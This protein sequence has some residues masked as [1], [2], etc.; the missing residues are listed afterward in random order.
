MLI[1]GVGVRLFL[2]GLSAHGRAGFAALAHALVHADG[3]LSD[4][5]QAILARLRVEA[6]GFDEKSE[7]PGIDEAAAAISEPAQQRA[8]FL[9]CI[10]ICWSDG[11]IADQEAVVLDRIAD[12][13]SI[14]SAD[15]LAMVEW[16]KRQAELFDDAR[17]LIRAER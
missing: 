11:V 16:V 15:R 7:H 5:E 12:A 17:S 8:A 4:E 9:E 3:R 14:G 13:W 2:K 6:G 10:G 1:T